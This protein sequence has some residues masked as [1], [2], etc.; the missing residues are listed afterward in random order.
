MGNADV[1][2][3]IGVLLSG[4]GSNFVALHRAI[5]RGD[6]P[7]RI[8]LVGSN[9]PD[10]P[11][12]RHARDLGIETYALD[13]RRTAS[14]AEH[15]ARVV[16]AL[17][18]AS[19][20]WV[21]LA[22][23]MRILGPAFVAAFPRRVLNIHPSLLPAFPGLEAQRQ[24]LDH[25]TRVAGCT[26]H[27]VDE[28]LDSGPIVEQIAVPVADDDDVASLSARILEVEHL[29]YPKALARLLEEPWSVVGRRIRFGPAAGR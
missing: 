25:G 5:A 14:R 22:G 13:H 27:L 15:D 17:R 4:R 18:A 21:C 7:A 29:A 2:A 28:G 1:P 8:V 19:V 9:V 24:A 23:Y 12:L 16:E 10:A 11:G 3:R 6:V 26:V 20:E